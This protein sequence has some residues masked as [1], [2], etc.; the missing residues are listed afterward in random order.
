[1]AVADLTPPVGVAAPVVSGVLYEGETLTAGGDDWTGETQTA[2][3]WQRRAGGG[4]VDRH[5]AAPTSA[6]TRWSPPTATP[7]SARS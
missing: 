5:R 6:P 4:V 7:T 2:V 1:M 3:Q